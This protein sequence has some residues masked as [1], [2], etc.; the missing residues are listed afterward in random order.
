MKNT[1]TILKLSFIQD[2]IA[3]LQTIEDERIYCRHNLVHFF[4]VARIFYI[5]TLENQLKV[6]KDVIYSIAF[7]HDLG[8][9]EEYKYRTN[10]A[11]ASASIAEKALEYTDFTDDEK[12]TI[13]SCIK[14]HRKNDNSNTLESLFY[15][16]DKLSRDCF[17]CRSYESCNWSESKKNIEIKY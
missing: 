8:R 4:D 3:D 12:S 1:N 2:L 15:K 9:A 17:N 7:L 5:L 11:L 13:L 10:H 16:A 6:N 14:S